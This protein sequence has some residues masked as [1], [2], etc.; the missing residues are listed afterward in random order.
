VAT[1]ALGALLLGVLVWLLAVRD[2]TPEPT[3]HRRVD[4]PIDYAVL[5]RAEAEARAAP[6]NDADP[7]PGPPLGA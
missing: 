1:L 3:V 2:E 5:E 7:W 4:R 6:P